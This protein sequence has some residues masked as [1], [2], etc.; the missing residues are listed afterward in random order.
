MQRKYSHARLGTQRHL[1]ARLARF[2]SAPTS[3]HWA[4]GK[5]VLRY[6]QGTK[7]LAIKYGR[8]SEPCR[9]ATEADLRFPVAKD[10]AQKSAQPQNAGFIYYGSN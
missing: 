3:A 6:L 8:S 1:F 7:D 10:L 2:V 9:V 4:A 5:A